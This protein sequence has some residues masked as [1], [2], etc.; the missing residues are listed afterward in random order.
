MSAPFIIIGE[1]KLV[2]DWVAQ[3]IGNQVPWN[4]FTTI[5]TGRDGYIVGG[6]VIDNYIVNARCSVHCAGDGINWCNREFLHA[7]FDYI[8]R[9]LKC[10]VIVNMVDSTN[11]AS[12]RFT[13][14]VG[15][16]EIYRLKGGGKNGCDGVIFEMQK[17]DCRWIKKGNKS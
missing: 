8:F 2:G 9:Q 4:A 13:A 12:L 14:H 15:F 16:T 17:K 1:D 3:R 7:V 5:G 11:I 6:A 10:N